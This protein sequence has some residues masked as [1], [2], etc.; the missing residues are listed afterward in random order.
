MITKG[1]RQTPLQ[2]FKDTVYAKKGNNKIQG[3]IFVALVRKYNHLH[4]ITFVISQFP[5]EI[6]ATL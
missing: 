1:I 5:F 6:Y 4:K 3:I 2:T